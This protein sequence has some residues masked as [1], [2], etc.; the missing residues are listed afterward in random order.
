MLLTAFVKA[1]CGSEPEIS[2]STDWQSKFEQR[3]A[4]EKCVATQILKHVCA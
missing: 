4:C 3:V 2:G 1:T